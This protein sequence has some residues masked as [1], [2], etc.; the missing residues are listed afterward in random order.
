MFP[1]TRHRPSFTRKT[2]PKSPSGIRRRG[3]VIS[4]FLPHPEKPAAVVAEQKRQSSLSANQFVSWYFAET[5]RPIVCMAFLLPLILG[6]ELAA[7]AWHSDAI[8]GGIDRWVSMGLEH[9]GLHL[10]PVLPIATFALLLGW[11][12]RSKDRW[13]FRPQVVVGMMAEAALI[14]LILFCCAGATNLFTS[15]AAA[16][17]FAND[18]PEDLWANSIQF[19][20]CGLY[21][22]VIFRGLLLLPIVHWLQKSNQNKDSFMPAAVGVFLVSLMFAALHFQVLNPAGNEFYLPS[23]AF[24][25]GASVVFC[26]LFLQRGLAIAVGA[27]V[28]YDLLTQ[29]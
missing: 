22:E 24:R 28:S 5:R 21:E 26:S 11:H 2:I 15:N 27:H 23:F 25:F 1:K 4:R 20:G 18:Q 10:I 3:N 19:L 29:F 9:I 7:L 13:T 14:G 8:R 16:V 6:Y 17:V 12:F